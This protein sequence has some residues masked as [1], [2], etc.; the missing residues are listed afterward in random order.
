MSSREKRGINPI[1]EDIK[2]TNVDD[3]YD[4]ELKRVLNNKQLL[5]QLAER[6]ITAD[7]IDGNLGNILDYENTHEQCRQFHINNGDTPCGTQLIEL[8]FD[9]EK[10]LRQLG[11]C[12]HQL[13]VDQLRARFIYSDFPH[14]WMNVRLSH[15]DVQRSRA[16][17]LAEL[18]SL[19]KGEKKWIYGFGAAGR[20]KSYMSV[21]A[22]N[23]I[24]LQQEN[25]T[26]AFVD[27]PTFISEN[28]VDFFNNRAN[29]DRLVNIL[30]EVDYLVLNHFGNEE[31]SELS[32]SA[33]TMPLLSARDSQ[34]KAT[35][36]L[37]SIDLNELEVLHQSGKNNQVRA[38]QLIEIIRDNIKAPIAVTGAKIY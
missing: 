28:M 24:A 14:T 35:I 30:S 22:L 33:I 15:V 9:G 7:M 36:I 17:F 10:I 2:L 23:E 21:A 27:F 32:R 18:L 13:R 4:I 5:A 12:P 34:G 8:Y 11:Q 29:V 6:G 20:G 31:I 25:A 37:S 26:F 19:V 16:P 38:R 1:I 3:L